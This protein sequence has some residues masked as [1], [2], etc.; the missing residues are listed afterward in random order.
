MDPTVY[1]IAILAAFGLGLFLLERFVPL[2]RS[3]A[4][5][6]GRLVV[7]LVFSGLALAAA[8]LSS[9]PPWRLRSGG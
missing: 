5:L 9:H 1:G 6:L 2:R 4:S 7:N 8:T 3:T